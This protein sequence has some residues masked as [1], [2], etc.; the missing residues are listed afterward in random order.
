M[1]E[2]ICKVCYSYM[3]ADS[4]VG[5]LRCPAC[6]F[7]KK[8]TKSMISLQELLMG[9]AKMEDLSSEV[10]ENGK[11]LLIKLNQFR[12][13][14]GSPMYVTSGYRRPEDNSAANG[15]K[16]S[17]HMSLQA[18]DFKDED[19]KLFEFIKND[20]SILE[21]CDLYMEDPRWT[22]N[23]IHLQNRAAG[24]RIFLPYSDGREP[25]DPTREIK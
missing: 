25:S 7:M 20:P 16:R 4:L 9:R 17:A 18:C 10:Q 24:R 21:R 3:Y 19:G 1:L 2:N 14:Y 23:W 13:E 15:S 12:T 8:Q 6:A 11:D 5:W 22:P